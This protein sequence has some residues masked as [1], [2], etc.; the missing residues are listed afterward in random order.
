MNSIILQYAFL[1]LGVMFF[2]WG[3]FIVGSDKF[4][5][6]WENRYWKEKNNSHKERGSVFYNRYVTGLGTLLMGAGLIYVVFTS[7]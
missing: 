2:V 5:H 7:F 4:F 1:W 3:T 6:F